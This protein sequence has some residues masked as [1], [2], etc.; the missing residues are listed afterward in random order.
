MSTQINGKTTSTS[1]VAMTSSLPASRLSETSLWSVPRDVPE[2]L[3]LSSPATFDR[4][5]PKSMTAPD[6]DRD[7][8]T[9]AEAVKSPASI[10]GR[11]ILQ[12]LPYI[13]IAPRSESTTK[14]SPIRRQY[15]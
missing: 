6:A 2:L 5:F 12:P 15:F 4:Y 8:E 3:R 1:L 13:D 10:L 11:E 7:P 9:A 14:P